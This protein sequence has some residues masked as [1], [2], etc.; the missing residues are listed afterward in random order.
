VFSRLD[1][2]IAVGTKLQESM[3][4]ESLQEYVEFHMD[5]WLSF[6]KGLK[7]G[8]LWRTRQVYK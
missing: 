2:V 7:R 3:G 6:E 5:D 1:N 8:A 4:D